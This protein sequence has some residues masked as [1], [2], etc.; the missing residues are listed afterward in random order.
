MIMRMAFRYISNRGALSAMA[1]LSACLLLLTGCKGD[2]AHQRSIAELNQKAQQMMNAGDFQG[3]ISRLEAAR[4]L[5]PDEPGTLHNLAIAYQMKGDYDQAIQMLSQL[6]DKP[7]L[8]P[9][10]IRKALGIAYESKADR[11]AMQAKELRDNPKGDPAKVQA[12]EAEA[13]ASYQQALESYRLAAAG[14]KDPK[15]IEEQ[16]KALEGELQKKNAPH[17][18]DTL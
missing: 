11:L 3:A 1:C 4:D 7:G 10:E 5:R 17:P 13:N 12:L 8:N 9:A 6:T 16:I 2:V 14:L 18:S 15:P